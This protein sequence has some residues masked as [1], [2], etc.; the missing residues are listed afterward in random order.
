M[1]PY[2]KAMRDGVLALSILVAMV[3]PAAA[4]EIEI[5]NYGVGTNGMPYGVALA[6]G[7]FKEFGIDITGIRSSPGG[8]R[9]S[10]TCWPATSPLGRPG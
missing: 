1:A 4:E 7:Y 6:K 5:S 9:R 2:M 10:A 3:V 8:P